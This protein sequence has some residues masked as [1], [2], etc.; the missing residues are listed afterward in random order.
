MHDETDDSRMLGYRVLRI[1]ADLVMR[2]LDAAIALVA[3][4]LR[5]VKS[6]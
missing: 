5:L 4:A 1:S 2:D 3:A 6:P